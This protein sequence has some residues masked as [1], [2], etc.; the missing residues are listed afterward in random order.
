LP[1]RRDHPGDDDGD[2]DG[3]E[4]G[5]NDHQRRR[6]GPP[7]GRYPTCQTSVGPSVA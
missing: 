6:H 2:L 5:K 4:A 3:R 7:G 1:A